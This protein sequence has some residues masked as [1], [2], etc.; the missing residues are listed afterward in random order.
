M[1][2]DKK[3]RRRKSDLAAPKMSMAS[4]DIGSSDHQ[5]VQSLLRS[6]NEDF[7]DDDDYDDEDSQ[8]AGDDNNSQDDEYDSE[9]EADEMDAMQTLQ[10]T[11][12]GSQ[13]GRNSSAQTDNPPQFG[14]G[15]QY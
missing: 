1:N 9:E 3:A 4:D 2:N 15:S 7:V 10:M 6:F 12:S 14:G 5:K 8:S 11:R 13:V